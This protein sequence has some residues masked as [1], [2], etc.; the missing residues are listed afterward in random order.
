MVFNIVMFL[1]V[2]SESSING[3]FFSEMI[4]QHSTRINY[5]A[6]TPTAIESRYGE[7]TDNQQMEKRDYS[8]PRWQS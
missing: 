2:S 7:E 6:R 3:D 8:G 1:L 5:V 4:S